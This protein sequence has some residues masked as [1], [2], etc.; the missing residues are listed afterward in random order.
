[1]VFFFVDNNNK[2]IIVK[3]TK[4]HPPSNM[5]KGRFP[6]MATTPSAFPQSSQYYPSFVGYG[7]L[8]K[9]TVKPFVSVTK[10]TINFLI[11]ALL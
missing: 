2:I 5:G 7:K 11:N 10:F 1:M 3:V 6:D 4:P 8:K 9:K